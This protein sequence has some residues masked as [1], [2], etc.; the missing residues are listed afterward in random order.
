MDLASKDTTP[1]KGEYLRL[2][3]AVIDGLK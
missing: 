2:N 1:A 3:Q